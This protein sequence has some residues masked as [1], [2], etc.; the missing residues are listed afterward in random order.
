SAEEVDDVLQRIQ[1]FDPVGVGAKDLTECLCIQLK[2]LGEDGTA[3][4]QIVRFHMDKLQ[5]RRFKELAGILGLEMD[6]LEAEIEIIRGLD[7]RPGQKY[8][9]ER[10]MY[11]VPD[12][13]IV[14]IDDEYQVL[15]N[16]EGL[17]R[18]RISPTYRRMV[19]RGAAKDTPRDAK[20]YV[21]NKLRSAFRLIKSLEERQ[22]TIYK[23]A[24]SIVKFQR[25]FLDHGVEQ[26]KPLVLRDVAEDIGMHESTVSRVVN[27]KYMHTHR[28]LFEMRFFFHSGIASSRGGES[29]S[30]LTVKEKIR[31]IIDSEDS[32]K[33]LSDSAI[34]KTLKAEGLQ[35]ARR[36]VAKYREELKIPSSSQRRRAFG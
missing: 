21:R 11:V 5:D 30:S 23:V 34:V 31:K 6:D 4:E 19:A 9:T 24:T 3:A 16:E 33:P 32:A 17:P 29:V 28:G 13:Y 7:P 12:V 8:N 27:N 15:L 35:I 25:G 10:S 26:M 22:R 18:L 2:H 36:T 20:E 1:G 14:K